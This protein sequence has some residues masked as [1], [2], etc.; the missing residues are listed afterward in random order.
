VRLGVRAALVGDQFVPGDVEIDAGLVEAVGLP[1]A[2]R[3]VAVPGFVDLQIN[4]F[5]GV[6]FR[7]ADPSGYASVAAALPA[8]GVTT[9][10]PTFYSLPVEGYVTSL[11][12]LSA[13]HDD[14]PPG[15]RI[16][17]AHLEGPFLSPTWAGAHD[18]RTLLA[19]DAVV[20]HRLLGA[21]PIAMMTL[22]P[23]LEG[24]AAVIDAL[25]RAGVVVSL[26]HTDAD[27]ATVACAAD[28]GAAMFT[29]L[30][31]AHRRF[32]PRDPGPAPVALEALAVGLICDGAHLANETV[33][34]TFAAGR[35]VCVVTDAVAPAGTPSTTW[36]DG[37][38]RVSIDGGAARLPDGTLAGSVTPADAALRWL[39]ETGIKPEAAIVALSEHPASVL[40]TTARVEPG[41][42]ADLVVLDDRWEVTRT[43]VGGAEVHCASP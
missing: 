39:I 30:W 33:R 21:G 12:V 35:R 31:N 20:L 25:V 27:A 36:S 29:H 23:E 17:G 6:D 34:L 3:G 11:Q 5:A 19:P 22:A 9:F 16:G 24:A 37:V 14:P 40:R 38:E 32:T 4:G 15:A 2:G 8:S 26:G 13:V 28:R 41:A 1:G 18:P 10:L 7:T 43:L 42:V